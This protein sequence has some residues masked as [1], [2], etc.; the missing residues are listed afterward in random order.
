LAAAVAVLRG[1]FDISGAPDRAPLSG[2]K[3]GRKLLK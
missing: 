2:R 1:F 3:G